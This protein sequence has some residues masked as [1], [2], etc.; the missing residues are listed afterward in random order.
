MMH[1]TNAKTVFL[2]IFRD[3]SSSFQGLMNRF[4]ISA[5]SLVG[6]ILYSFSAFANP[7]A[8][9]NPFIPGTVLTLDTLIRGKVIDQNDGKPLSQVSI[10]NLRTGKG[11]TSDLLGEYSIE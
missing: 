2:M 7:S 8:E 10:Q 6:L 5:F 4:L 1:Q 9:K 11:T 3:D